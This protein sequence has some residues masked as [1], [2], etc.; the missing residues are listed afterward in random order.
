MRE[1]GRREIE[2]LVWWSPMGQPWKVLSF[3][4]DHIPLGRP[5]DTELSAIKKSITHS[6]QEQGGTPN[7]WG[8]HREAA[9]SVGRQREGEKPLLYFL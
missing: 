9:E 3:S 6:Y 7:P 5:T 4:A 1:S 8:P 2:K